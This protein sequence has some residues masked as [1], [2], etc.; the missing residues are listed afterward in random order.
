MVDV[1]NFMEDEGILM[2]SIVIEVISI[3]AG[4]IAIGIN[5]YLTHKRD[6]KHKKEELQ[7]SHLKEMLEWLNKM[8]QSV[9]DISKTLA[10][11]IGVRNPDEKKQ[12]Q[13]TFMRVAN[14]IVEESIIFCDSYAEINNSLG[15]DLELGELKKAIGQYIKELRNIQKEYFF[16][17]KEE[18]DLEKINTKTK[19]IETLLKKRIKIIST[20]ISKLLLE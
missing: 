11:A 7:I 14:S 8:Q 17:D 6:I 3:L 18:N 19:E 10:D 12:L 20:E 16:P 2:S 9:F 13:I 5:E 15:I 4:F 1:V